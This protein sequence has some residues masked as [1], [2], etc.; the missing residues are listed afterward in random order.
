MATTTE[1]HHAAPRWLLRLWDEANGTL[2][3][4][5]ISPAWLEWTD[6]AGRWGDPV[7]IARAD[8]EI[9]IPTSTE[10]LERERHR[11]LHESDFVRWGRRGGREVLRRY[12]RSWFAL[13]ALRRWGRITAEA[14]GATRPLR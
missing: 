14:L 6:E 2:P 12:G 8:L 13:L 1:L 9:M 3:D 11:L 4:G 7:E 5:E 10:I